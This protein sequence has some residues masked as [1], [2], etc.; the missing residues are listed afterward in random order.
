MHNNRIMKYFIFH[1]YFILILL[2]NNIY[3]IIVLPFRINGYKNKENGK[4]NITDY[5]NEYLIVDIFTTIEIGSPP[6]KVTTLISPEEK[7]FTLSS[8]FCEK[9]SLDYISDYSIVSKTGLYLNKLKS[10]NNQFD[11]SNFIDYQ[12]E[13]KNIGTIIDSILLYNTTFLTC[14]PL[15][16]RSKNGNKDTKIKIDNLTMII[17]DYKNGQ[18]LCGRIG[19]GSP[20][21]LTGGLLKL[22]N[23]T[24]FFDFLKKNNI[25][26][27]YSWTIKLHHKEEGRLI[28]GALPHQ[29]EMDNFYDENKYRTINSFWPSDVYFP[30]S[31]KFDSINFINSKNE[32]IYIQEGL[33]SLLAPNIGFI[34]GEETYRNLILENYFQ[35]LINKKICILEKTSKTKFTRTYYHFATNGIYEIFHCNKSITNE[36]DS[37]PKINF[38]FKEQNL[39][40]SLAFSDL[41]QLIDERYFFLVIFPE[42]NNNIKHNFY[43][44]IPFYK[45][46]QFVFNF[47]SKTIGVYEQTIEE[48]KGIKEEKERD[49]AK[50]NKE[51]KRIKYKRTLLEIIFGFLLVL[52]AYFI[53]KKINEQRKK[54]ANEL[55]D[56][57]EYYSNPKK[58]TN[59]INN[60]SNNN[61]KKNTGN[62][63]MS[64][65]IGI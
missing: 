20:L 2:Y 65:S 54:R 13:E 34:I 23:M 48:N 50:I 7:T 58:D 31:I 55:I 37:F 25:I 28:I 17:K 29:Y 5:I 47:D 45:A 4:Y 62:L 9:K 56:D 49:K 22:R 27:D 1:F 19:I 33:R 44:G 6:Q 12:D 52:I 51:K 43:L 26:N 14:Q 57:Y 21:L 16:W 46:Y 24:S 10:Y 36:K 42:N 39:V 41:F 18:K 8:N 30:W 38:E 3:S 35:E 60:D 53:G 32:T 59:D 15:E 61:K 64:S 63:E 40:F 11:N